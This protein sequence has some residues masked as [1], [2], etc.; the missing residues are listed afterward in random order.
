MALKS[1]NHN[2]PNYLNPNYLDL[3]KQVILE[4]IKGLQALNKALDESFNQVM[5]KIKHCRGKLIFSGVGKSGH[6]A[7]KVASTFSSLGKP[8]LFM[9][10]A[11]AIHGDLGMISK[12]DLL[13]LFS[14]SGNTKEI[15]DIIAPIQKTKAPLVAITSNKKSFLAKNANFT[16]LIGEAKEAGELALAP[17]TSTTAMLALGDA[18]AISMIESDA[19]FDAAAF[20]TNHPGGKLGQKLMLVS[21]TMRKGKDLAV[22]TTKDS[23]S[24]AL[25]EMTRAKIGLAVVLESNHKV[26]GVFSDGD[27]RRLF[28]EKEIDLHQSIQKFLNK[29]PS[30]V[31]EDDYVMKAQEIMVRKKIGE[32]PVL[33]KKKKFLGVIC[34]KDIDV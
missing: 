21:E 13:F 10:A 25:I 32:I 11:E 8:S 2:Q 4:E 20:A 3:G 15:N 9:H 19:N 5:E 23:L 31:Y 28:L 22:L 34:L 12:N 16:L 6:I 24:Q 30:F 17:T 26:F 27:I 18:L 1:T 7:H 29:K 14:N 33:N